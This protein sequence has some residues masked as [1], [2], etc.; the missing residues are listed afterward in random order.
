VQCS[1]PLQSP[2]SQSSFHK[3]IKDDKTMKQEDVSFQKFLNVLEGFKAKIS[4][5]D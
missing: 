2:L 1:Q 3:P 5:K 4:I